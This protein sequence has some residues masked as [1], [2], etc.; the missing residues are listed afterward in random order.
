L[1]TAGYRIVE[2]WL[3]SVL[4][5]PKGSLLA[6]SDTGLCRVCVHWGTAVA[7]LALPAGVPVA[8]LMPSVVD[9]LEVRDPDEEPARYQLSVPGAFALA[10]STTLAQNRIGDGA[11]L[12][13]SRPPAPLPAAPGC[14]D[15][16]QV[17]SA[18]LDGA[19]RRCSNDGN[20]RATRLT[21]AAAAVFLTAVGVLALMR[22]TFSP[23]HTREVGATA[24]V[25]G[26]AGL[27]ALGLAAMA[28]RAYRDPIA[29]LVLNVIGT[30]LAAVAG[31]VAV[32]G[33]P[34]VAN[35]SL[36]A[37]AAAVASVLAMRLSGCDVVPLTAVACFAAVIAAAALVGAITAAP[38]HVIASVCGVVSL[39]LLGVVARV[40]ISLA[41][42][43]PRLGAPDVAGPGPSAS[44]VSTKA[45]RAHRWLTSLLAGLSS[46]AGAAA[47]ITVLAGAPHL[48]CIAFGTVTCA[49]LLLRSRSGEGTRKLVFS[50]N[51]IV[52]LAMIFGVVALRIPMRGPWLAAAT[53]TLAAA[54]MYLGFAAKASSPVVRRSIELLEWLTLA[55]LVPLT[56]WICGLYDVTRG[57]NLT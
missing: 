48:S 51:G 19:T 46:S 20:R 49:L 28:H 57:L 15:V 11:V 14:F 12:V 23:S 26:S 25:L 52:V 33:V 43:S 32:P 21:G 31:F 6:A 35:V 22:N 38:L 13:L 41:G 54:A 45:I 55:A 7:D 44:A 37:V 17:V 9:A 34:S 47:I 29:G 16:A 8:V 50:I 27:V 36:A 2:A 42:L 30:A 39:G 18:A 1:W 5:R 24:A 56:C 40:S 10:P 53:V 4:I 3:C